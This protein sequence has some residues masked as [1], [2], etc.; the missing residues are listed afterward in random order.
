M[1]DIIMSNKVE[2]KG[3]VYEIGKYYRSN[4]MVGELTNIMPMDM[5]PF[6]I[7]GFGSYK[8]EAVEVGQKDAYLFG[9][10]EDAPF[11][12]EVGKLYQFSSNGVVWFT[13]QFGGMTGNDLELYKGNLRNWQF[14]RPVPADQRAEYG[15]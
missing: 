14:C 4:K 3:K 11:K 15:D 7:S 1:E 5:L 6:R 10:I 13:E 2:F 8:I 12:P 9:T